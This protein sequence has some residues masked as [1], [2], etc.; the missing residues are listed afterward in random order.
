M[1]E[2]PSPYTPGAGDRPRALV[3]REAQLALAESVRKQIEADYAANC[4]IFT[5]LRGVG[6]TVLLKE[7]RDRMLA[8]GWF[9]VYVQLRTKISIGQA[10][11]EVALQ[12]QSQLPAGARLGRALKRLAGR[13]GGL[14][15][16]S[17][18]ATIGPA[19]AEA[20]SYLLLLSVLEQLGEAA[21]DD[22]VGVAI[23][24]DELQTLRLKQLGELVG[25]VQDLR[26]RVPL[27]FFGGGLPYLPSYLAKAATSTERFRYENTD[28]LVARDA[29]RAVVDPA[30]SEGVTWGDDA[31]ARVVGLAEGYPY[32]LQLYAHETWMQAQPRGP[33]REIGID[34]VERA[35]PSVRRQLEFG[36]Y[37]SRFD[38][39]G[40]AQREYLY[41]MVE[42][43]GAGDDGG[44]MTRSIR[45]GDV[46]KALGKSLHQV[47]PVR[48]ALMH[49]GLI[50][51]PEHGD[52]EFSI[53]GFANYLRQRRVAEE[54]D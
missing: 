13:G 22:G 38:K 39:T 41:A 35:I 54:R 17:T 53:P 29:A 36:L 1:N 6:K 28:F 50:H 14:Q 12:A 40:P 43:S 42:L 34:D 49:Q 46:S 21:R 32:F 52:L 9:A 23:V 4:L 7:V 20:D 11:A 15:I 26:D 51:A 47:S 30:E 24:V 8:P 18:G 25:L 37:G 33:F 27:A 10:F 3:G 48:D 19:S 45:S 5:G 2:Q 31:L 44:V 16:L